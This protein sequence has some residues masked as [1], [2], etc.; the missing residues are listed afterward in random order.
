MRNSGHS[1]FTYDLFKAAYDADPALKELVK[2]FDQE[3]ITLKQSSG[4]ELDGD[5][6][7]S[8]QN[9]T[10]QMAKRANDLI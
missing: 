6:M 7:R 8:Q 1:E 4:D 3:Q 5:E 10:S 9:T 2:D